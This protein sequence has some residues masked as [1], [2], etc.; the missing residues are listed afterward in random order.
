MFLVTFYM[1]RLWYNRRGLHLRWGGHE[2]HPQPPHP[3]QQNAFF[4]HWSSYSRQLQKSKWIVPHFKPWVWS[5]YQLEFVQLILYCSMCVVWRVGAAG[6]FRPWRPCW[7]QI[8]EDHSLNLLS[9]SLF[10]SQRYCTLNQA[11]Y[12]CYQVYL[13]KDYIFLYTFYTSL[14]VL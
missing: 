2:G 4:P 6:G 14:Y 9:M 8:Q 10:S 1:P 13:Y 7:L 12:L 3:P 11:T 5:K